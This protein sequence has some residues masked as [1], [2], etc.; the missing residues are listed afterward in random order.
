MAFQSSIF[1]NKILEKVD[2]LEEIG[3]DSDSP[4]NKIGPIGSKR[5][6]NLK[7]AMSSF[8][9]PKNAEWKGTRFSTAKINISH[10]LTEDCS[11]MQEG[12]WGL[13]LLYEYEKSLSTHPDFESEPI[14]SCYMTGVID[15]VIN[16]GRVSG[17]KGFIGSVMHRT[18]PI[19]VSPIIEEDRIGISVSGL[20]A[21][22]PWDDFGSID[23][24][25]GSQKRFDSVAKSCM[26]EKTAIDARNIHK[27]MQEALYSDF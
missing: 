7:D 10:P 11:I 22:M 14:K 19:S 27:L 2:S 17:G 18:I 3:P 9:E 13:V 20:V 5:L 26:D 6:P 12:D 25:F 15:P 8:S 21:T 16:R 4:F 23:R 1:Y 24:I